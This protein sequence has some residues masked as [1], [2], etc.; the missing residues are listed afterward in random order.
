MVLQPREKSTTQPLQSF[1]HIILWH[2]SRYDFTIFTLF[3]SITLIGPVIDPLGDTFGAPSLANDGNMRTAVRTHSRSYVYNPEVF[4]RVLISCRRSTHFDEI[5]VFSRRLPQSQRRNAGAFIQ[6]RTSIR[7]ILFPY[8]TTFHFRFCSITL[9]SM[10]HC[11]PQALR[12]LDSRTTSPTFTLGCL[13]HP[14][15]IPVKD[16]LFQPTNPPQIPLSTTITPLR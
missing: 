5:V 8:V 10:R 4:P 6:V 3:L 11:G 7:N 13:F 16:P 15:L 9:L 1:S 2:F 12:V 14:Q